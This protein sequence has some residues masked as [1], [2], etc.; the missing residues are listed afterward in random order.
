MLVIIDLASLQ[1]NL[2]K[3]DPPTGQLKKSEHTSMNHPKAFIFGID[4]GSFELI[5]PLVSQGQLPNL[6]RLLQEGAWA[7]SQT[8]WPPHTGPGW[9]SLIAAG[10]PGHHGIFQ[11][12][13]T[14]ESDY[15][16]RILGTQDF[17][18]STV[19]EWFAAA[20]YTTGL[21]NIPMSHPPRN[22]SGYQITWP[23]SQTL[24]YCDPP[25]LLGQMARAGVHFQSDLTTMYRGNLTYVHEALF[26]VKARAEA[27][28]YL[29][30]NDPVDVV[31]MVLTEAD[32][33]C[34]HYW[35]FGD[36]D[37]PRYCPAE[38][39]AYSSAI[40]DAYVAIDHALG[41]LLECLPDEC[42][43]VV[44]SDHG[45]GIGRDSLAIHR[46]LEESGFF[47][48]EMATM[49]STTEKK[50]ASWFSELGRQVAWSKTHVYM[51]VPGCYALNVNLKGRQ[52]YG[53]VDVQSADRL[54]DEVTALCMELR[55]P[56]TGLPVFSRV[57]RREEA[58]PGACSQLAP[59]L[60]LIPEDE[61]LM[62]SPEITGECWGQSAQ[63]GLHHYE[64]MWIHR[65]KHI[66]PGRLMQ[67]I[68]LIDVMP[69]LFA[70][71]DIP[72]PLGIP[73]AVVLDAFQSS[74]QV[75]RSNDP[76]FL[77]QNNLQSEWADEE[78]TSS[79]RRMGYL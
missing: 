70:D 77:Q 79:L 6:S 2:T 3:D 41:V 45:F 46:V 75:A 76:T 43:V 40:T 78:L 8:T 58:F 50:Q 63:T 19:W 51:P 60:L 38:D 23:L 39:P 72:F 12:F 33:I 25:V 16:A 49:Y 32:R 68:R 71:L 44:V 73:G 4:G 18:C 24:R 22:L 9:S 42:S 31:M 47:S 27:A 13:G 55:Y 66:R 37:H 10:S 29:L 35:H 57:L 15:N 65:S 14:Q 5:A 64:G 74:G 7:T 52:K 62:V 17:Q 36:P 61:S 34:H 21:I 28:A 54:Q 1:I 26:N 11:F 48:T 56:G 53:V 67:S 69:T 30:K 59:D 20:G